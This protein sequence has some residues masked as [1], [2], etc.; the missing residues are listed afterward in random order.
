VAYKHAAKYLAGHY[1]HQHRISPFTDA[2]SQHFT[3]SSLNKLKWL[4][5]EPSFSAGWGK[6]GNL[7]TDTLRL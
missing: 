1:K 3:S 4:G 7:S 2:F 6:R 5:P